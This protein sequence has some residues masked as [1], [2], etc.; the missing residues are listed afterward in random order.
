VQT[1]EVFALARAITNARKRATPGPGPTLDPG[2]MIR[3]ER[4]Y[5]AVVAGA[6]AEALAAARAALDALVER[7]N[8][9][10]QRAGGNA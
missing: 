1:V 9:D 10:A 8:N 4:A 6:G 3:W 7:W 5:A 2:L